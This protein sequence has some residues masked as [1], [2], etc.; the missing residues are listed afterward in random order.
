MSPLVV[1]MGPL[2]PAL[3]L[4]L[5]A[6]HS[7]WRER[8]VPNRVVVAL[9]LA[10]VAT[11]GTRGGVTGAAEALAAVALGVAVL[12]PPYA[13]GWMG[14]GDV[15]LVAAAG[16]WLGATGTVHLVLWSA[17][18]GGV[19]SLAWLLSATRAERRAVRENLEGLVL[20]GAQGRL[21]RPR[22]STSGV[23][24]GV[25]IALAAAALLLQRAGG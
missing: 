1:R 7:D 2:V 22:S 8:R 24:Y 21:E 25:A 23:P 14:A 12:L 17:V 3:A 20:A 6:A 18:A 11:A 10:G 19:L 9:A 15:K 13:L 5:L 16:S 4:L